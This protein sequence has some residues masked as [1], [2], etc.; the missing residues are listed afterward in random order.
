M[1][2]FLKDELLSET[3][4]TIYRRFQEIHFQRAYT[5]EEIQRLVEESGLQ[6][7]AAYEAFTKEAPSDTSERIYV[8]AR[9]QGKKYEEMKRIKE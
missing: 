9:E 3:E 6:F 5:L 8:I 7:V 2:L 1:S 4:G